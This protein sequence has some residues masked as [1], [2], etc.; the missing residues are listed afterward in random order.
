MA[1]HVSGLNG[2]VADTRELAK[3]FKDGR[4]DG[5]KHKAYIS[6]PDEQV[7]TG[8]N[9]VTLPFLDPS[10]ADQFKDSLPSVF[11]APVGYK[12]PPGYKGHPLPYDPASLDRLT[13]TKVTVVHSTD[14]SP[15]SEVDGTA[16]TRNPFLANRNKLPKRTTTTVA[17]VVTVAEEEIR[18]QTEEKTEPKPSLFD[19]ALDPSRIW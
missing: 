2:G 4:M 14:A 11:I 18:P 9:K 3:L 15:S 16:Q 6:R 17:P 1:V 8:F 10:Q 13:Q 19:S 5:D 7:P 12:V